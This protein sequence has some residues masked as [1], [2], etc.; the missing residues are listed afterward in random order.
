MPKVD[1]NQCAEVLKRNK[2]DP[3]LLRK[4]VEEL[5]LLVARASDDEKPPAI[6][7]QYCIVLSDPDA[8]MPFR[9]DFAGWVLEIPENESPVTVVDRIHRAAY[10]FNASKR[11][12]LLPVKTV[13]EAIEQVPAKFFKEAD[14]WVKTKTPVL[15]SVTDN[16][17]PKNKDIE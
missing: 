11:G 15:I 2:A 4:V 5:N 12:Q 1:I 3:E 14:A 16:I 17:I 8:R 7:K 13:G 9:Y 10:E 6:R